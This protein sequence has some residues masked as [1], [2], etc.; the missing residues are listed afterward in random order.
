MNLLLHSTL[1]ALGEVCFD[2]N[3]NRVVIVLLSYELVL[4]ILQQVKLADPFSELLLE[5]WTESVRLG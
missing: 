5:A 2:P 3:N 1:V 4:L